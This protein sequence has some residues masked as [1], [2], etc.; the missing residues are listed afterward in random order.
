MSL[1]SSE[2]FLH[3]PRL[4][5]RASPSLSSFF[6]FLH[7]L[8]LF[9]FALLLFFIFS[10]SCTPLLSSHPSLPH[11]TFSFL[12][13]LIPLPFLFLFFL[14]LITILM[15]CSY[16]FPFPPL[17]PFYSKFFSLFSCFTPNAL[18]LLLFPLPSFPYPSTSSQSSSPLLPFPILFWSFT[19]SLS[20]LLCPSF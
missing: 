15:L 5:T 4:P 20:F 6:S 2:L 12:L 1:P 14:L 19:F 17:P 16:N 10:S 13:L 7:R 11:R 9:L 3:H 18:I 8:V